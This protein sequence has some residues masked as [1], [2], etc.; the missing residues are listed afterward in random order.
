[1]YTEVNLD[2]CNNCTKRGICKWFDDVIEF[3]YFPKGL[4]REPGFDF[5]VRVTDFMTKILQDYC[6]N[7]EKERIYESRM[8]DGTLYDRKKLKLWYPL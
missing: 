5:R 7:F 8:A 1:V 6:R 3:K 2:S 4:Y